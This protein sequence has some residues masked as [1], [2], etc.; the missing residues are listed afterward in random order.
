MANLLVLLRLFLFFVS[1]YGYIQ[2]LRKSIRT[3]FCIGLVFSGIVSFLFLAGILNLLRPAAWA[4]FAG[5]LI[6]AGYSV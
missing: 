6:L 5:G 4:L 3:E 1:C 2:Y